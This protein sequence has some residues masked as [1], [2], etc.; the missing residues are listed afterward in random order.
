LPNGRLFLDY[1][2]NAYAQT[3]VAPYAVRARPGAPVATPIGWDELRDSGLNSQTCTMKNIFRRIGQ[4]DDPWKDMIGQ[5]K[6]VQTVRRRLE[7][8]ED[9]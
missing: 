1:L 7:Q 2:R 4:K 8:L 5:A 9:N 3:S 6:S